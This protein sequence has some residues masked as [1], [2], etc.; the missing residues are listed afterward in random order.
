MKKKI[1][2]KYVKSVCKAYEIDTDLLFTKDKRS[3]CADARHLLYWL[4]ANRES[5]I[6]ITYIQ[7]FMD[8]NGYKIDHSNVIYGVKKIN[9]HL[10][11]DLDMKGLVEDIRKCTN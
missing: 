8:D 11:D 4:C 10:E 7:K 3:E 2:N 6:K 9:R 5:P 1:F